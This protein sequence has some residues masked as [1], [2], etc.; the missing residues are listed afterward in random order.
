MHIRFLL[1]RA[2]ACV[3]FL[4]AGAALG[5]GGGSGAI[6]DVDFG[7][8]AGSY[9]F[10]WRTHSVSYSNSCFENYDSPD[11]A[12]PADLTNCTWEER[13]DDETLVIELVVEESGDIGNARITKITDEDGE[14][15][16][17]EGGVQCEL[18]EG[19]VCD[20]PIRCK[21]TGQTCSYS[22]VDEDPD[23]WKYSCN[24][25]EGSGADPTTAACQ[26]CKVSYEKYASER[27]EYCEK[28]RAG[29]YFEFTLSVKE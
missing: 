10:T 15:E 17:V 13:S 12:D 23:A 28:G 29:D 2:A 11:P 14:E 6:C 25:M 19:E 27:D 5:C 21:L 24:C 7:S 22:T 4:C 20:A 8:L 16:E 9:S 1:G 3:G 26:D 18:L